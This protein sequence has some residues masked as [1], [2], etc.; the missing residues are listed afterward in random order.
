MG[1]G[2]LALYVCLRHLSDLTDIVQDTALRGV[3]PNA[4]TNTESQRLL[5]SL[6]DRANEGRNIE[7]GDLRDTLRRAAAILC[8]IAFD[9][10]PLLRPLIEIPLAIFSKHS[11]RLGISIWL[12]II[13]EREMMESQILC[14]IASGWERI[15]REGVGAFSEEL[16]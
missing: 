7:I 14:I 10:S 8:K 9:S 2:R 12:N 11:V 6:R 13:N 15:I 5:Q 1:R 4:T 3:Q 16:R